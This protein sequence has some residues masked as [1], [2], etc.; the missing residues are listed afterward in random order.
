MTEHHEQPPGGTSRGGSRRRKWAWVALGAIVALVMC[1]DVTIT[2]PRVHVR[3]DETV[4]TGDREALER[5]HDLRRGVPDGRTWQYELGDR[6]LEN[7]RAL[8]GEAA[9]E[10]TAY[11]DRDTMTVGGRDVQVTVWYPFSGLVDR[12]SALVPLHRSLWLV[13]AGGLL[14]WAAHAVTTTRARR[15]VVVV[16]LLLVGTLAVAFP[17]SPS[18]V[19]M[20][21]SADHVQSRADFE[22]WFGGR[23]RFEKHLSQA[24]LLQMYVRLEPTEAAPERAVVAMSRGASL[25]FLLGALAI[26][27]LERWSVVVVR[28][29]GLVLLA[30]AALLYFGWREF[31]YLSLSVM[32]F[33]LLY[34]GL[35]TGGARLEAGSA[36][37]GLGAA[38]HGVGLVALVGTWLAA[39][40]AP[41]PLRDRVERALRVLAWGT[42]AYLGWVFIYVV[43]VN[44]RVEPS[45]ETFSSW[46]PWLVDEVRE[47]R[48]STAILS[49][50]GVRDIL[51]S[52]WVV[53]V[54]LLAVAMSMWRQY[55]DDVRTVLWYIPPSIAFLVLRWP[56][57]GVGGGIDLVIAGFP[58]IYALAWVCA[59]DPKRTKIAA[60]L[61]ISAHYAFWRVVLDDQFLP[62]R[63][64]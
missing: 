52:A 38:L 1:V 5:E 53:G 11:I 56:F 34:R 6:S 13:L 26:G 10:D 46:R 51:M 44:L 14:L 2:G 61:L 18:S 64:D 8:V 23:V 16:A 32:A 59:H 41:G 20:G 24:L 45:P 4:S 33:P 22:S 29:L 37:A 36:L 40:G 49:M 21:G 47:R 28:Y 54:P 39:W 7:I 57:E 12:P 25:W 31:G 58:A 19:R 35:R 43:V 3:W 62:L 60:V 55:A 48:V 50:T 17:F 15:N 27:V 63:T 30:P 9:V 42:T